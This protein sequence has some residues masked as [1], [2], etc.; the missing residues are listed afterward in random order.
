MRNGFYAPCGR[1]VVGVV[2]GFGG[3]GYHLVVAHNHVSGSIVHRFPGEFLPAN[4]CTAGG[5]DAGQQTLGVEQLIGVLRIIQERGVEVGFIFGLGGLVAP[6]DALRHVDG[7]PFG[8][9]VVV[10]IVRS[11]VF[12]TVPG[13]PACPFDV[14]A[15][16]AV[17][18]G[19]S[20][21]FF[22]RTSQVVAAI[23]HPVGGGD[24]TAVEEES[25]IEGGVGELRVKHLCHFQRGVGCRGDV[26]A[27][28]QAVDGAVLEPFEPAVV[29][30]VG[31]T[32]DEAVVEI[33]AA[34]RVRFVGILESADFA[35]VEDMGVTG[36]VEGLG[37]PHVARRVGHGNVFHIKM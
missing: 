4:G 2:N 18:E 28:G 19:G 1:V 3:K 22:P 7:V 13:G 27:A 14:V 35:V 16:C 6:C 12:G 25:G 21:H 29:D 10:L 32:L 36:R 33:A 34:A 26:A 24:V 20:A 30:K 23:G 5:F 11:R 8:V 9:G 37:L 15:Q 17:E 31:S